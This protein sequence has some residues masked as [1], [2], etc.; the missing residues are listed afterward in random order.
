LSTDS[1]VVAI[2]VGEN[3]NQSII[4]RGLGFDGET[5]MKK[6]ALDRPFN[7]EE[8]INFNAKKGAKRSKK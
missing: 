4:S 2:F 7:E 5:G 6:H 1:E 3:F 8:H